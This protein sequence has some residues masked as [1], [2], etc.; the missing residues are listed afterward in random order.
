MSRELVRNIVHACK[1]G[2]LSKDA[3]TDSVLAVVEKMKLD[4]HI[5]A[6][7]G[8]RGYATGH[9][10]TIEDLLGELE[11]QA[12]HKG[13]KPELTNSYYT[14][15]RLSAEN[16]QLRVALF[17]CA[18]HCQGGHS[19]AGAVAAQALGVPFPISMPELVKRAQA[20][21]LDPDG[22]W[23]WLKKMQQSR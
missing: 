8:E 13:G 22:L 14:V 10:D 16:E 19:D 7:M 9:G 12:A 1:D 6:W 21:G 4:S 2:L 20:E 18:S 17:M 23:P 11:A 3:A 15:D 5:V